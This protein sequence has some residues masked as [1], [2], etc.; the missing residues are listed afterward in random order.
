MSDAVDLQALVRTINEVLILAVLRDGPKHGYQIALEVDRRSS[1]MFVFQ[2]GTLYPILHR[3][4]RDR[5]IRGEW[6]ASGGRRRKVYGV[7]GRGLTHLTTEADRVSGV[8]EV[9]Q[10]LLEVD[11]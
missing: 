6:D 3:L 4:E 8:W 10:K 7:T 11:A 2:H 5:L 9:L 1:A